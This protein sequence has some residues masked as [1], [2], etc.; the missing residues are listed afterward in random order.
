MLRDYYGGASLVQ[1]PPMPNQ[2]S[3]ASGAGGGIID[4]LIVVRS[5]FASNLAK[6]ETQEADAAATYDKITQKN[7]VT[8]ALKQQDAKYNTGEYKSADKMLKDL[9]A[10]HMRKVYGVVLNQNGTGAELPAA[11]HAKLPD[12]EKMTAEYE[13]HCKMR[14]MEVVALPNTIKVLNNDHVLDFFKNT[15]PSASL[16]QMEVRQSELRQ[17]AL[18]RVRALA[19]PAS[20]QS[21][22]QNDFIALALSG[23]QIGFGKII[24]MIDDMLATL[25]QEQTDGDGKLEYCK[26][27]LDSA[28]D[29]KKEH[30][31]YVALMT[32]DVAVKELILPTKNRMQK[33]YKS[34]PNRKLTEEE[35]ITLN[36]GGTDMITG[37]VEQVKEIQKMISDVNDDG[38]EMIEYEKSLKIVTHK[39]LNRDSKDEIRKAFRLFNDDLKG[40]TSFKS[41]KRVAKKVAMRATL[42]REFRLR[43]RLL[44]AQ[45]TDKI[46]AAK[47]FI[48]TGLRAGAR[49][50]HGGPNVHEEGAHGL[51]VRLRHAQAVLHQ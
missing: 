2:H 12:R 20:A 14:A 22:P 26:S 7:R 15:L 13:E 49:L 23:K 29:K 27:Q 46:E 37:I 11:E 24:K 9:I 8:T 4:I 42:A 47:N 45:L 25:K 19:R 33:L 21:R 5:D 18:A 44:I 39:I 6:V 16:L 40:K 38:S 1:Q 51:P 10:K 28:D 35:R 41:L 30:E 43:Q 34:P 32:S 31:E 17:R 48:A 3:K 50:D 36:N